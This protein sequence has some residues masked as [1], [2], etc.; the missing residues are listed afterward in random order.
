MI[1]AWFAILFTGRY[2]RG[3]FDYL[4]GVGR[5]HNRVVG[6]AEHP[7]HRRVP[8]LQAEPVIGGRR[9][10]HGRASSSCAESDRSVASSCGRRRAGR[11]AAG[12]S[13]EKPAGTEAAGWPVEFQRTL[14]GTHRSTRGRLARRPAALHD[15]GGNRGLG[16]HR[17]SGARRG[18]RTGGRRA[19]RA[20]PRPQQALDH[21][22][23]DQP[24]RAGPSRGCGA[25]AAAGAP[26]RRRAR[27]CRGTS[28]RRSAA[29]RARRRGGP[30]RRPRG[31]ARAAGRRCRAARRASRRSAARACPAG[32]AS[33]TAMRSGRRRGRRERAVGDHVAASA[34]CRRPSGSAR[35]SRSSG[36]SSV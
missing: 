19:R 4:V 10:A 33:E 21:A 16:H 20:A 11:R 12:R 23:R 15:P 31:R 14:N 24:A 34:R 36:C 27:G 35:R 30:P 17:A 26:S 2:P 18:R 7:R 13:A 32:K 28:G 5:W 8:A 6:Y 9:P 29:R 22:V 3:I 25:R 1:A